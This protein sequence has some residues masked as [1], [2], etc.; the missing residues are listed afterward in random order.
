MA[1]DTILE[2]QRTMLEKRKM[3]RR[4]K[5]LGAD[6]TIVEP[7]YIEDSVVIRRSTVGPNVSIGKGTVIEDSTVRDAIVGEKGIIAKSR[8]HD[9]LIGDAVVVR[10][11]SGHA[12]LGDHGELQGE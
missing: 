9:S 2:T 12:T 3:A 8:I 4:P 6:A 7:V 5:D 10:G 1:D 11:F